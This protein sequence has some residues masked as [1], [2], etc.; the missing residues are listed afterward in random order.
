MAYKLSIRVKYA[1]SLCAISISLTVIVLLIFYL[2]AQSDILRLKTGLQNQFITQY[3]HEHV[4]SAKQLSEFLSHFFYDYLY[5]LDIEGM[6]QFIRNIKSAMDITTVK[7]MDLTGKVL[8]DGTPENTSFGS[9]IDVSGLQSSDVPVVISKTGNAIMLL[10]PIEIN[11]HKTG[12]AQV[13]LSNEPM[14]KFLNNQA[15]I[16]NN[17]LSNFRDMRVKT[18]LI[19]L[20]CLIVLSIILSAILS[21]RVSTPL[22][23]LKSAALAVYNGQTPQ[24]IPVKGNDELSDFIGVF[25]EMAVKIANYTQELEASVARRTKEHDDAV[26]IQRV[27]NS[28]LRIA[29]EPDTLKQKLQ[30]ILDLLFMV[31]WISLQKKGCIFLT[32]AKSEN[33]IMAAERNLHKELLHRCSSIP[34]GKCLCGRAAAAGEAV[35]SDCINDMHDVRFGGM[36]Q[37]GHYCIPIKS[38]SRIYGV[39]NL[40]LDHG[41]RR[42]PAEEEFLTAVA[43]SLVGIIET[44][45]AIDAINQSNQFIHTVLNS[46]NDALV[47]I[48]VDD[49]RIVEANEIFYKE[50]GLKKDDVINNTCYRVIHKDNVQCDE[51]T[52][53]CPV[54]RTVATG[55]FARVEHIHHDGS[56]REINV[57]CSSSPIKD[58][59]GKTIQCVYMLRNITERKR[60]ERQLEQM[61]H[62]DSLTA[63]PNRTL[64]MD[65]LDSALKMAKREGY[66]AALLFIDLDGFKDVNDSYGHDSGDMLLKEVAARLLNN[67]RTTDT[68][69]RLGGDEFTVILPKAKDRESIAIVAEKIITSL[70]EPFQIKGGTC[71]IGASI[72]IVTYPF[73]DIS[74][75]E[76]KIETILKHADIAMYEV[77]KSLKNNYRFYDDMF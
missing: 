5:R 42:T 21:K 24:P 51:I 75:D 50:Y 30:T 63:L 13:E 68:V 12:Y 6:N 45:I 14:A 16:L 55:G 19:I 3:E 62:Y 18:G 61:A 44:G 46:M 23:Q 38:G 59:S 32:D 56:G 66:K 29:I 67:V 49:Y 39:L 36:A 22:L 25:N 34:F 72:G 52:H 2:T 28:I 77:K 26:Q 54:A 17:G 35:F 7:I 64:F 40:Y 9:Y 8:T 57:A 37:H 43:N 65:R 11:K 27:I 74:N 33:L 69:A 71:S 53:Q 58:S 76:K 4:D 10:F 60:M 41:H 47:V 70:N 1:L 31:S 15:E 20:L 73:N 48:N